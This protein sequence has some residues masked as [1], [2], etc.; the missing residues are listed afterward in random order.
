MYLF[1][2]WKKKLF[3]QNND[4]SENICFKEKKKERKKFLFKF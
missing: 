1:L 3:F 4:E 2:V